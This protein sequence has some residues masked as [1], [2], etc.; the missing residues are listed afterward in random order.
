M[1]T[2]N[3]SKFLISRNS[4]RKTGVHFSW[5][6]SRETHCASNCCDDADAGSRAAIIYGTVIHFTVIIAMLLVYGHNTNVVIKIFGEGIW[7]R[8]NI[9]RY[10]TGVSN[11]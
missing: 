11:N 6:C 1:E 8:K 9:T 10:G 4:G 7:W 2:R 5:N 3:G